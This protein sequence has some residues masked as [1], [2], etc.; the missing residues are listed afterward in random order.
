MN[1]LKRMA[2]R[3]RLAEIYADDGALRSAARV[4]NDLAAEMLKA[5][6]ERDQALAKLMGEEQR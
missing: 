6:E 5:A 4:L 3:V 2:E 1:I